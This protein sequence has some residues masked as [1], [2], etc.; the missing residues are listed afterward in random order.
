MRRYNNMSFRKIALT[1]SI[2]LLPFLSKAQSYYVEDYNLFH[3]AV[4]A[5]GNFTQIDGDNFA[6]YRK[7]GLNVGGAVYMYLD[8]NIALSLEML[9]S[10][11]GCKTTDKDRRQ[12]ANGVVVTKYNLNI[13]YADIPLMIHYFIP[14]K[15]HFGAGF[16]LGRV[17]SSEQTIEAEPSMSIFSEGYYRNYDVSF[18]VNSNLRVYKGL[19]VNVR[20]QYSLANIAKKDIVNQS[21][22]F[23]RAQQANNVWTFRLMYMFGIK[24]N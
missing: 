8:K 1:V 3:G 6:G 16:A 21:P 7:S 11:K 24:D 22:V 17:I 23:G 5:G 14:Q 15:S 10:E 12:V 13:N 2:V 4:I 18:L 9:Y 19:F 20:F